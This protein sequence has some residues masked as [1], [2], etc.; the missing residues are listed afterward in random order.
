MILDYISRIK[1]NITIHTN[2]KASSILDGSYKSVFMGRSLNFEDLREYIPGDNIRDIDWKASSRSR[3]LLVKRFIA[4]KKH[5][6]MI[7]FDTG[8]KMNAHTDSM[9]LKRDVAIYVAGTIAYLTYSNGDFIGSLYNIDGR[10]QFF[11]LRTRLYDVEHF[12]ASYDKDVKDSNKSDLNMTLEYLLKH[13]RRKMV[14]FVVSDMKGINSLNEQV[15]KKLMCQHDMLFINVN[16]A[17]L[18][19]KSSSSYKVEKKTF[20]PSF[21]AENKKLAKVEQAIREDIM[22]KNEKMLKHHAILC[23]DISSKEEITR[24]LT[25]LLE[26][27]RYANIR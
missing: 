9:Q 24:K 5:N 27:H 10:M 20:I 26:K 6:I 25:E 23:T 12:L 17:T 2:I 11:P 18:T 8:A 16:D 7:V 13:F 14:I 15:L 21:L 1:S 4:E 3:S 22:E 19:G